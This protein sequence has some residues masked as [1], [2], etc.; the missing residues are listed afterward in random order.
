MTR[1]T[2]R[3]LRSIRRINRNNVFHVINTDATIFTIIIIIMYYQILIVGFPINTRAVLFIL[4]S[5]FLIC[6]GHF[7]LTSTFVRGTMKE[8]LFLITNVQKF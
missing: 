1:F 4:T 5:R 8:R 3:L 7:S 2:K 6:R